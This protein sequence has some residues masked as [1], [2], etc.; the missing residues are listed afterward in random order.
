MRYEY[1]G[2]Q[3]L[4][5]YAHNPDGLRGLMNVATRLRRTGRIALLLGQAGNRS[6][7]DIEELAATAARF[8]PDL[9]VVKETEAYMRGRA[10]GEVP[11]ILRAALLRAGLLETS[12][13]VHLSE[14]GAV[15]RALAWARPGD[16]LVMPVHDRGVRDQ[17]LALLLQG[18]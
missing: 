8:R 12:I 13:E 5:D 10:P 2:A 11:E 16:V 14:L 18:R 4:I 7:A 9:V 3:V 15:N 6:N 1:R 17:V